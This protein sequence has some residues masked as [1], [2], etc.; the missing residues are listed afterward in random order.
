MSSSHAPPVNAVRSH[1]PVDPLTVNIS[2]VN[3]TAAMHTVEGA[4]IRLTAKALRSEDARR[5]LSLQ[6]VSITMDEGHVA[7]IESVTLTPNAVN[8]IKTRSTSTPETRSARGAPHFKTQS[9]FR[10]GRNLMT[11]SSADISSEASPRFSHQLP[12]VSSVDFEIQAVGVRVLLENSFDLGAR[13][14]Q[15][16]AH[17]KTIKTFAR[18]RKCMSYCYQL[19]Y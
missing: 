14:D 7:T 13:L 15:L 6:T 9:P 17:I 2:I 18:A 10:D 19:T 4:V 5:S 12:E 1:D 3:I 8:K 16:A 11:P